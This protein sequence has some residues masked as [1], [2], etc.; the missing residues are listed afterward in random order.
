MS[1]TLRP[2]TVDTTT[3]DALGDSD[4][5]DLRAR[6]ARREVSA[7]EVREAAMAR[8]RVANEHLNAVS[9]WFDEPVRTEAPVPPDGPLAGIPTFVKDNEEVA[10]FPT[11]QGSRAVAE[12]P[13][14]SSSPVVAALLGLGL[15]PLGSST[16]P[17]FGLTA[18]TESTRFGATGNPWDTDRSAGGSSGGSAALVA[19]GVVPVAHGNDGG[20][21]IR[22]P[23]ACCR[24]VGLKP[25]RGRLPMNPLKERIPVQ[26]AAQG[27]LTR[28]VRDTAMF[29]AAMERTRPD[30]GLLPIGDVRAPSDTRLRVGM[31]LTTLRDLPLS[32]DTLESVR[33]TGALLAELGHHVQEIPPPVDESFASDFLRYWALLAF[34]LHRAGDRA[35]GPG[36]DGHR[37]EDFTKGLSSLLVRQLDRVPGSLLRLRR[38]SND[39]DSMFGPYDVL[40][41][42]VTGYPAPPIGHLGPEVPFR[43][44]LVRLL[45]FASSTPIQ[46]VAGTPAI[47][48]PLGRSAAGLPLGVHFAAPFGQERR[49]LE[50]ALELEQAAP[51]PTRPGVPDPGVPDSRG[52]GSGVEHRV[53][54]GQ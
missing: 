40:L 3:D 12:H 25:T 34:V 24:L 15:D 26:I 49:L 28:T 48:L 4:A 10:G 2:R 19:A 14:P 50:L 31:V 13:A 22:I 47:S 45:Q 51:W 8:A 5:T 43:T 17:E 52:P 44:H 35:Y 53:A 37:V 32:P 18:S 1:P 21:S 54:H 38:L 29:H 23:A 46:N 27:V 41:S 42:P 16:L 11:S 36:F 9:G 33:S 20:G 39:P 6:L 30:T 7:A